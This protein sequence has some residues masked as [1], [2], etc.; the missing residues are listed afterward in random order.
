MT[1]SD[2][3]ILAAPVFNAYAMLL[4]ACVMLLKFPLGPKLTYSGRVSA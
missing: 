1:Y 3:L 2:G 4:T